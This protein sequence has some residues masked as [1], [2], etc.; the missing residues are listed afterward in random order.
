MTVTELKKDFL[1]VLEGSLQGM[2]KRQRE[3]AEYILDHGSA[4]SHE[5]AAA[6][7]AAAGVSEST[8]VRF[9]VFMGYDG[10]PQMQAALRDSLRKRMTTVERIEDVNLR[11]SEDEII[12]DVLDGDSSMITAARD[13]LDREAFA[14]TVDM[15]LGAR[16]I[17]IVGMRSSAM[18]AQFMNYYLRLLFDNVTLVCPSGGSE[19]F[20]FLVNLSPEDAVFAI[21]YPR[22]SSG[23]IKAAEFAKRRG[24]SVAVLT[25]SEKSP[26]ASVADTVLTAKSEM[27]SFVDSLVAPMSVINAII[28]YIGKKRPEI[29]DK[30]RVLEDVWNE[31][32]VYT[33]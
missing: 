19:V 31:Y 9:A 23:T 21:S 30:F 8:V 4:A 12:D 13:D 7:G 16:R 24:A 3:V 32:K 11:L 2:S 14:K 15:L 1:N 6:L 10:Y 33:E 29:A 17:Y 18:L 22:Y 5:T 26:I 28:A 27:V 20:E 25:D